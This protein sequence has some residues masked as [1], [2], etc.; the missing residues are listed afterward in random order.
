[1]KGAETG[2]R[3][4][5]TDVATAVTVDRWYHLIGDPGL[6]ALVSPGAFLS[7]QATV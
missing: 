3:G 6:V 5:N 4:G 7:G 2:P 1:M